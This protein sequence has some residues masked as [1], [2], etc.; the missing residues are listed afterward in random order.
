MILKRQKTMDMTKGNPMKTIL[1]FSV[2]FIFGTI[3]QMLYNTVDTMVVGRFV[4]SQALA[5]VGGAGISY[6]V[7][8]MLINGFMNGASVVVAQAFGSNDREAVRKG[9]ATSCLLIA[10]TGL[11]FT[12]LGECLALPLLRVLKTPEDVIDGSL[13][14]LRIMYIGILATGLYNGFAAF[15][16]AVGDSTTPL[17]ALVISSCLNVALDLVFVLI[18][19]QGI[20]GV[21]FAT[22]LSQAVSGVYCRQR[23]HR[24]IPELL[25]AKGEFALDPT[26]AKEM[27]RIGLPAAFSSAVVTLSVMLIQRAVNSYGST[28]LA[29]YTA[30]EKVAQICYSLSYSIGV[31]TGTFIGQ[32]KGA[33]LTDRI[34]EG[35]RAGTVLSLLYH[36]AVTVL[37]L[38]LS[39]QLIGIFTVDE[40]VIDIAVEVL[41]ITAIASPLLGLNFVF[42]NFLRNVSDVR[43]TIWMSCAEVL[44]RG[45]L[46]YALGA[47]FGYRGIWLATPIGWLLSFLIGLWRYLSGKWCSA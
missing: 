36:G 12:V 24:Q 17:V 46:P 37:I 38:L 33:G 13:L 47:R 2:P 7:M 19:K 8:M 9:Y 3:F 14:Y 34:K 25:P 21:A 16:R 42:Q 29:A 15:L 35:L 26:A 43:P 11:V 39:R 32:N 41:R 18:L 5:A 31:A 27:V 28:V 1:A 10:A 40:E 22:I 23:M 30:E 6:N 20:A 4:G 44:S 45:A